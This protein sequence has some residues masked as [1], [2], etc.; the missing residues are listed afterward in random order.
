MH[1]PIPLLKRH[2]ILDLGGDWHFKVDAEDVGEA[3]GWFIPGTVRDR[4]IP[5]PAPWQFVY[6]D[7]RH[8]VG[9][10]WYE[11]SFSVSEAHRDRRIAVVFIAVDYAAKVWVNGTVV[12]EHVGG[13]S[14]FALDI[15]EQVR[16]GQENTLTVKVTDL[17]RKHDHGEC[18]GSGVGG[19]QREQ[20]LERTHQWDLAGCVG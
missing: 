1:A 17:E 20:P 16:F 6:D 10:A 7:L 14:P 11:R 8:Y 3:E 12:G 4:Q 15:S 9:A 18:D 19:L 13:Y 5:V 2:V